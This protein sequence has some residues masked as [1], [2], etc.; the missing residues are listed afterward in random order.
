MQKHTEQGFVRAFDNV[1]HIPTKQ[2]SFVSTFITPTL[3]ATGHHTLGV[4][5]WSYPTYEA[6]GNIVFA[7][8][9]VTQ[10]VPFPDSF[11]IAVANDSMMEEAGGDNLEVFNYR[12]RE[13]VW[14]KDDSF[15]CNSRKLICLNE[16]TLCGAHGKKVR[17]FNFVT[18][19]SRTMD[20]PHTIAKILYVEKNKFITI[21]YEDLSRV[22]QFWELENMKEKEVWKLPLSNYTSCTMQS[23]GLFVHSASKILQISF[24]GD[25]VKEFLFKVNT[26]PKLFYHL[27]D[28]YFVFVAAYSASIF[29]VEKQDQVVEL[30]FDGKLIHDVTI[31]EQKSVLVFS[32]KKVGVQVIRIKD[33][34]SVE[35][36]RMI[37]NLENRLHGAEFFDL[38]FKLL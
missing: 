12:T 3:L 29:D 37:E 35:Q 1:I 20:I 32:S 2:R 30:K 9:Y 7:P 33:D 26:I 13:S 25:I 16:N 6:L 27:S 11:L 22:I 24:T 31:N 34:E 15:V 36:V 21:I 17:I 10:I 23:N 5:L 38:A 14:K 19:M 18:K 4:Q 8:G 28:R